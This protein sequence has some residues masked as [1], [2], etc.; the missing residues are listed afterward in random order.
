[1]TTKVTNK[2]GMHELVNVDCKV[3]DD[4]EKKLVGDIFL[5]G[6][7]IEGAIF[8]SRYIVEFQ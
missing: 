1:M 2:V 5:I 7:G 3:N 8:S 4:T 6:D